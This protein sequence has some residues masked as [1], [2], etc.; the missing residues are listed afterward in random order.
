MSKVWASLD[1]AGDFDATAGPTSIRHSNLA[2]VARHAFAG[3]GG[4]TRA[5]L[6]ASSG[7]TRATVS[8]LVAELISLR[9]LR[10]SDVTDDGKP[11]RPGTPLVPAEDTILSLGMEVNVDHVAGCAL[12]L[13][14]AVIDSFHED[15]RHEDFTPELPLEVL[16][17]QGSAMLRRLSSKPSRR[18]LGIHLAVPGVVDPHTNNV[19]Y[20]P[21]LQWRDLDLA[22]AL[23]SDFGDLPLAAMND[24]TLQAVSADMDLADQMH[25]R[26]S[27]LYV[28][29]D[30]GI[31][32]AIMAAGQPVA[33]AHGWAGEIGHMTVDPNG[34][35]CHCGAR[36][37]LEQYA[38][39]REILSAARLP[40]D[41]RP[42]E[43]KR[44]FEAGEPMVVAAVS[45]AAWGLGIALANAVNLLDVE[46]VVLGTGLG[47]LVEFLL[48][49]VKKE[50]N[51]RLLARST[52]DIGIHAA[53]GTDF[54]ASRGGALRGV[55]EL[56]AAPATVLG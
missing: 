17:E 45:R 38:G 26:G 7:L 1:H 31:G 30:I 8:R 50:M 4:A 51:S 55:L 22:K 56:L 49:G 42:E 54:P 48:P 52:D 12:D 25:L 53:V 19:V 33:G 10:E 27:F 28:S 40:L 29:G 37:C 3:G 35:V 6:A 23:G 43:V 5:E 21:N 16:R 34:P 46:D 15:I 24:A 36:G 9:I 20:A 2:L 39:Q 14:G 11:G 13:T 47:P 44:R 18:L 32:G 41:C